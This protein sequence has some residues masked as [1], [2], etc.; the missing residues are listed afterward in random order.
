MPS[1]GQ[2]LY[3][4]FLKQC[5][6]IKIDFSLQLLATQSDFHPPCLSYYIIVIR[7]NFAPV[8]QEE[9]FSM[10]RLLFASQ[11]ELWMKNVYFHTKFAG[12]YSHTFGQY[13]NFYLNNQAC[14]RKIKFSRGLYLILFFFCSTIYVSTG[15]KVKS[16]TFHAAWMLSDGLSLMSC[17][18]NFLFF[19]L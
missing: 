16:W 3:T 11:F 13:S 10:H 1:C 8:K 7:I 12:R 2:V 19:N 5:E 4:T 9:F 18:R 6:D 14:L 17:V 15:W